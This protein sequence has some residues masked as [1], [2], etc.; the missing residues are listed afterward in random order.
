MKNQTIIISPLDWGLGHA[1]RMMEV[2]NY[3][4]KD[5]KLFVVCAQNA[6]NYYKEE[7]KEEKNISLIFYKEKE[8]KYPTKKSIFG[9]FRL[10]FRMAIN[11][12]KE[13]YFCQKIVKKLLPDIIISDNRYGFFSKKCKSYFFTHQVFPISPLKIF[14]RKFTHKCFSF[15]MEKFDKCLI[16]DDPKINLA[17]TLSKLYPLKEE[18]YQYIGLLSRF[19]N[20][21]YFPPIIYDYLIIISGI[22]PQR[23]QFE[24]YIL[25]KYKDT[26][27]K[28]AL[29]RG[30]FLQEKLNISNPNIKVWDFACNKQLKELI[31]QSKTIICKSGYSTIMDCYI[32]G[33]E[34]ILYPTKYQ[35]EQ[36]YLAN[37][38]NKK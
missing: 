35:T 23:S 25:A 7:L 32:L 2:I 37:L 17:G 26:N 27:Q 4:K 12:I 24:N 33:K 10:I 34:M 9:F 16:I 38:H 21:D 1:T 36:E 5:N 18:K 15:F 19:K 3:L 22:E 31:L 28:I 6:Y 29:V 8:I 13:Y 11:T 30:T 20:N 14:P